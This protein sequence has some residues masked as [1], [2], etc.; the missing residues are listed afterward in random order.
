MTTGKNIWKQPIPLQKVPFQI[1]FKW[2]FWQGMVEKRESHQNNNP[3]RRVIVCSC[4]VTYAFQSES[5]L[6]SCLN[7]KEVLAQ[8]RREI[9]SLK[10]CNWTRTQNH[11]VRNRTLN[12]L[13]KLVFGYKL[14]GSGL[15]SSCS[16]LTF[17]DVFRT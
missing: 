13:A 1:H 16:T 7:V 5:T 2:L 15:E 14:S 4:H 12:N 8:C 9:W 11:L 3:F 6:Y 17:R 10:Y